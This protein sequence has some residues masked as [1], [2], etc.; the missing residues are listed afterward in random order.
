[1]KTMMKL[2]F[3]IMA[4]FFFSPMHAQLT[5]SRVSNVSMDYL[6]EQGYAPKLTDAGNISFK[7]E[8][9]TYILRMS[10]NDPEFL[11]LSLYGWTFDDDQ[12][13]A[14]AY[15]AANTVNWDKKMGRVAVVEEEN[16]M[17]F[18]TWVLLRS[19][20]DVKHFFPRMLT[21]VQGLI[22]SFREEMNK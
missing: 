4:L 5:K 8:G 12:E 14:R 1:M 21:V 11:S 18:D 10:D 3:L 16:C 20:D 7:A 13:K 15:V 19:A 9:S 6:R 17:Y 22:S 2:S